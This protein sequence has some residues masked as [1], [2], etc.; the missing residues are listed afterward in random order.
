M[1]QKVN[2]KAFRLGLTV[3]HES[4]WFATKNYQAFL[5]Q[6]VK[7]RKYLKTKLREAGVDRIEIERTASAVNVIINAVKTGVVIGRGGQNVETL[8]K[9]IKEK[10]LKKSPLTKRLQPNIIINE[11][12]RPSLAA[13]VI[14]QQMID[15]I[16]KRMPFRRVMKQAISRVEKAGAEG[17]KVSI[18]GRLNGAEIARTER[19]SYGSIPLHTLRADV[20]YAR[21]VAQ[22]IYGTIGIKVWIYRGEV[23]INEEPEV[24]LKQYARRK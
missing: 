7:L 12:A 23:F 19:L 18:A 11:V 16:E 4:K 8:K 21:G 5:Q 2:P 6:D 3:K 10:F 15:D 20:D 22:T 13:Q 1:G 14:L 9:D 17:V 24:E